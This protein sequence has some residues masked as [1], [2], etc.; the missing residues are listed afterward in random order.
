[1]AT[2]KLILDY[3]LSF[4]QVQ[5]KIKIKQKKK[6]LQFAVF[7]LMWK[8]TNIIYIYLSCTSF[9]WFVLKRYQIY[10]VGLLSWSG[11]KWKITILPEVKLKQLNLH[12]YF[13]T[14][15]FT[16]VQFW[17]HQKGR[18]FKNI[19]LWRETLRSKH[20]KTWSVLSKYELSTSG[21]C[22]H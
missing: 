20:K 4:P 15:H 5:L 22:I 17:K 16:S 19:N 21:S 14:R 8:V 18:W 3:L 10:I 1:M 7:H 6:T 13:Q 2:F 12:R 11:A 9:T